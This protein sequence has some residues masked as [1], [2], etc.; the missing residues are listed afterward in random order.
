L[1]NNQNEHGVRELGRILEELREA[2]EYYQNILKEKF[3]FL[4]F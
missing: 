3:K 1:R 2:K 4:K